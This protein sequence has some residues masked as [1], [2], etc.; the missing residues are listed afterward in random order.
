[1]KDMVLGHK[2]VVLGGGFF[3]RLVG[4]DFSRK[5]SEFL[6]DVKRSVVPT[7]KTGRLNK[8][9][10][11]TRGEVKNKSDFV[12][13]HSGNLEEERADVLCPVCE[14]LKDRVHGELYVCPETYSKP[15]SGRDIRVNFTEKR[16][17]WKDESLE[18]TEG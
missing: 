15:I 14:M 12:E 8:G 4:V 17:Q 9:R 6:C 10:N 1:M 16:S 13:K 11:F 5:I 7:V 3:L 2:T 18:V